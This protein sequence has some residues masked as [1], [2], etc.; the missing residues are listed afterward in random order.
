MNATVA[1]LL[2]LIVIATA[3]SKNENDT[4]G[5]CQAF[6]STFEEPDTIAIEKRVRAGA[7]AI[8]IIPDDATYPVIEGMLKELA[9]SLQNNACGISAEAACVMCIDTGTPMS[10]IIVTF[11]SEGGI[12]YLAIDLF[13]REG[14][15]IEF[16]GVH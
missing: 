11:P 3:C 2:L 15:T 6:I 16:L 4:Y 9:E 12:K 5:N 10:E 14:N 8:G 7:S 1:A 13:T